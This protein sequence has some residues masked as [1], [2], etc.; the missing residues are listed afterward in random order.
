MTKKKNNTNMVLLNCIFSILISGCYSSC[1]QKDHET[2]LKNLDHY[3]KD[4]EIKVTNKKCSKYDDDNDDYVDCEY[5][6][7]IIDENGKEKTNII[8]LECWG[9]SWISQDG[10]R[11]VQPKIHVHNTNINTNTNNKH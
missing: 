6:E 8:F 10:C 4:L 5:K 7:T 3:L 2:A 11:S 9:N 1:H